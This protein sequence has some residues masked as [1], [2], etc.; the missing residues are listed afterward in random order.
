MNQLCKEPG[1][2]NRTP[3]SVEGTVW[4]QIGLLDR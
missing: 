2:K 3:G 4:Q 1:A